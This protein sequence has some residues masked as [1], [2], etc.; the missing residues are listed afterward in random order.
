M[1]TNKTDKANQKSTHGALLDLARLA[2][3]GVVVCTTV[4]LSGSVSLE[5]KTPLSC[6]LKLHCEK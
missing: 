3:V 4:L 6:E 5:A 2:I 1:S